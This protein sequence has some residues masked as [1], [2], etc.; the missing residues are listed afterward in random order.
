MNSKYI[1]LPVLVGFMVVAVDSI[2]NL[3]SLALFGDYLPIYF[4]LGLVLFLIP[5]LFVSAELS[6]VF[7]KDN[8]NGV[9]H[10]VIRAFGKDVGM[11]AV[12]L[13]WSNSAIWFPANLIFIVSTFLVIFIPS[14]AENKLA[15]ALIMISV[16]WIITIINTRGVKESARVAFAC[17]I[18]GVVLPV[19]LLVIF[20]GLWVFNGYV[21]HLSFSASSLALDI[22]STN[23]SAVTAVIASFLGMELCSVHIDRVK[24]PR[25]TYTKAIWIAAFLIVFLYFVGAISIAMIMPHN[26][27]RIYDGIAGTF[28]SLFDKFDMSFMTPILILMIVLGSIGSLINWSVSPV[29]GMSQ[30]AKRGYLPVALGKENKRGA[31][32]NILIVQAIVITVMCYLLT[33]FD[34]ISNFYWIF[35]SLSTEIYLL[36]YLILFVSAIKIRRSSQYEK[37]IIKNDFVFYSVV[38]L[39]M[40]GSVLS[41]IV[42]FIPSASVISGMSMSTFLI[43]Y[44]SATVGVCLLY[45]VFFFYKRIFHKDSH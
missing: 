4:V 18:L 21:V 40:F 45:F 3:P 30:A 1:S 12:W 5:V 29:K 20:V 10:W 16:F 43:I 39:G 36:M 27:I 38:I 37:L 11:F 22:N 32:A 19:V 31:P 44:T 23:I 34:S 2:R 17:M 24:E 42:G 28:H 9:Y 6:A 15:L 25:K 26:D 41:F 14:V 8:E 35:L 33:N 13:Q 7:A